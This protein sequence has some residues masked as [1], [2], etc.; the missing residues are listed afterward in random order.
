[1]IPPFTSVAVWALRAGGLRRLRK[2]MIARLLGIFVFAIFLMGP[3][4]CSPEKGGP[5]VGERTR[6]G[7]AHRE[8]MDAHER[9][10][11]TEANHSAMPET[12]VTWDYVAL[13]DSL[14]AGVGAHL[15]YVDRYAEYLH[16]D[17]DAR[18]KLTNLGVSG[19]T[20][21]QL[22][23]ALRNDPSTRRALRGAEVVTYNIGINDL[24]QA[25][26]S[27]EA[28]TCGGVRN[29]RCLRVAAE[30]FEG[31]W[32][33][34]TKEIL[35]L[36]S[37]DETIIR[38]AGLGYLPQAGKTFEPYLKQANRHIAASAAESGIPYAE[39]DLGDEDL[40][41]DGLHPDDSGYETIADRL[42]RLGYEPLMSR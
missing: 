21:P 40:G 25:R 13:G 4:A 3:T 34:I 10:D 23:R 15:G 29:Q 2:E 24:G 26:G 9:S 32:D 35:S 38:T 16:D 27:Y 19:Q 31:N 7:T 18:V 20:S 39:A 6:S 42:Q 37:P 1:L 30:E 11:V 22:L 12:P 33:A 36:R 17:T 41:P 28:K 14:A 8:A 5:T